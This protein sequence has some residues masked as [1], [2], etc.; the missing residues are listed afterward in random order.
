M[1]L[2]LLPVPFATFAEVLEALEPRCAFAYL[3]ETSG[4]PPRDFR[5]LKDVY[6]TDTETVG[7]LLIQAAVIDASR[8][9]VFASYI[10]H[11]CTTVEEIWT[12]A[13]AVSGCCLFT[14]LNAG[15]LK[16]RILPKKKKKI[17][18]IYLNVQHSKWKRRARRK[19]DKPILLI[20]ASRCSILN[21]T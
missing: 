21:K 5:D 3:V 19:L 14:T 11:G 7:P 17:C 2:W 15:I 20:R 13:L 10:H 1:F 8:N 9:F 18:P 4:E 16:R 6:L 12:S